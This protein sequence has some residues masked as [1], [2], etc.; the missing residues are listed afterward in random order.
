MSHLSSCSGLL[1]MLDESEVELQQ[2]ALQQIETLTDK[3]WPE[4]AT[5][6]TKM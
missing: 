1:S 2:Y 3:F 5:Q 4:I 6:I